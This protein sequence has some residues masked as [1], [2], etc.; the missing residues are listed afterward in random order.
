MRLFFIDIVP[1][2]RCFHLST[3]RLTL[4]AAAV[5]AQDDAPP[6]V[7]GEFLDFDRPG[8]ILLHVGKEIRKRRSLRHTPPLHY[9]RPE[10]GSRPSRPT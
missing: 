5:L 8:H 6:Q 4:V 3:T 1:T 10:I 9:V 2:G 7:A